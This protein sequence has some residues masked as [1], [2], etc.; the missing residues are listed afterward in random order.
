MAKLA[1]IIYRLIRRINLYIKIVRKTVIF[2]QFWSIYCR[3]IYKNRSLFVDA[4]QYK[5]HDE[6]ASLFFCFCVVGWIFA[7]EN[8]IQM[9]L[10][11]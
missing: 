6:F 5:Q 1:P 7:H 9:Q 3:M 11:R 2:T 10:S 4:R 8:P